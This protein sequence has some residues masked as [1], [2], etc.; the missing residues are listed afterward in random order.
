MKRTLVWCAVAVMTLMV[1]GQ[2][3][4]KKMGGGTEQAIAGLEQQW[5]DAGKASNADAIAPLLAAGFVNTT[6]DGTV[7]GKADTL[8]HAKAAKWETNKIGNVKV[9]VYGKTA[10]ATGDWWGKGTDENGKAVN[11]HER[12]TDT[13]I[14]MAGGK[15]QCVASQ[16]TTVKM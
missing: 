5:T 12:W 15:W 13:W 1:A 7:V 14:E 16:G 6:S 3:K 2:A 4:D 11:S 8:A 10:I 9:T